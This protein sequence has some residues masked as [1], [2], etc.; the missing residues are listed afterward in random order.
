MLIETS[1]LFAPEHLQLLATCAI[2]GLSSV[3]ALYKLIDK[4]FSANEK[5]SEARNV[6]TTDAILEL[7]KVVSNA[8]GKNM[9]IES[10]VK[11]NRV[12]D[13]KVATAITEVKTELHDEIVA[14][15]TR[16]TKR[17]EKLEDK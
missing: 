5:L 9:T 10:C 7:S 15:E 3:F 8:S 16:L 2:A 13:A 17:I 11:N 12:Q 1:L 6:K 4:R 14:V